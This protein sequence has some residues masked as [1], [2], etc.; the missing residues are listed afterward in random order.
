MPLPKRCCAPFA[1]GLRWHQTPPSLARSST[2]VKHWL[3]C[4]NAPARSQRAAAAHRSSCAVRISRATSAKCRWP[5]AHL[6]LKTASSAATTCRAP[7]PLPTSTRPPPPVCAPS[8]A[9]WQ[10]AEP[11]PAAAARSSSPI[12]ASART[13]KPQHAMAG[14][15][16]H[17]SD[18]G[19]ESVRGTC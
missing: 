14:A 12:H 17:G 8:M 11:Q 7:N 2:A 13:K 3:Q 19:C 5:G 9:A 16:F 1:P 4:Q 18:E 6:I 10:T 15:V